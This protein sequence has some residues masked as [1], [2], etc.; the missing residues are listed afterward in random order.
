MYRI[1]ILII[2]VLTGIQIIA[3]PYDAEL[4]YY[5]TKISIRNGKLFRE[6][7]FE[8]RINN[9]AGEKFTRISIPFSK[10][11]KVS[12]VNGYIR[13]EQGNILKKLKKTDITVRSAISDYSFYKD[14]YLK[15]FTLKHNFYPY[16]VCYS[17]EEQQKE[18]LYLDYWT[19]V[20]DI[21]IPT[22]L[23]KLKI[24]LPSGYRINY[25]SRFVTDFE[26]DTSEFGITYTWSA[27]YEDIV[28]DAAYSPPLETLLPSVV[29]VPENFRYEKKGSF[30]SW[31]SFGDW[32]YDLLESLSDL[33]DIEK[34]KI[35][36]LIMGVEDPHDRMKILYQYLQDETRYINI[37]IETGG[38]KPYPASYVAKNKYGDCKALSN[39]FRSVL[40]VAGIDSWYTK[41]YAGESIRPVDKS[42]PSQQFN[43]IILYIPLEEDTVWL[44]CTSDGPFGYLGTFTQNRDAFVIER[45]N[46]R[47]I[48]T[49]ALK[50]QEV[51][52]SRRISFT[53]AAGNEVLADFHNTY[54]GDNFESLFH[55]NHSANKF[56]QR[57]IVHKYFTEEGFEPIDISLNSA[58][59]D[60]A[61]LSLQ[62]TARSNSIY[63]Y[64]GNEILMGILPFKMPDFETPDKRKVPVQIDFPVSKSDTL[65]YR[66]PAGF[67]AASLPPNINLE[68]IYGTYT[69]EFQPE[70]DTITVIKKYVLRPGNYSLAEYPEFYRFI[71][72]IREYE[73]KSYLTATK[74]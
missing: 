49:P 46:S 8:V 35:T 50:E 69:A 56:D 54:R 71:N 59:R 63:K 43:H 29:V 74:K 18:F 38:I 42:F 20:I 32:Q 45:Q 28:A 15:E 58:P 65:V 25:R 73:G 22:Y 3:Q 17:Y 9:R 48:H 39:Y 51:L 34:K 19:P 13:D 36:T 44:D 41:V 5:E 27:S 33:P 7:S 57:K 72:A 67:K 4:L 55:L 64:F 47:F 23:A 21:K 10:L 1:L 2:P 12:N 31:G 26:S 52:E 62:Y 40:E 6:R 66:I 24:E 70:S 30:S 61:K 60:S 11:N 16:I 53:P 68:E 37:S 14:E